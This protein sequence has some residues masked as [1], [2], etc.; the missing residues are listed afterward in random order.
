MMYAYVKIPANDV[1]FVRLTKKHFEAPVTEETKAKLE[2]ISSD[3]SGMKMKYTCPK[4]KE[5]TFTVNLGKYHADA[6]NDEYP[7][8]SNCAEGAYLFKPA[9]HERFQYDFFPANTSSITVNKQ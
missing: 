6:G 9:R 1:I 8:S 3:L 4:G 5:H 2:L 7:D